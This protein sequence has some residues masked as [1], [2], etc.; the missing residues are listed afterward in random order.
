[1][2]SFSDSNRVAV[3]YIKEATW[4]TTPASPTMTALPITSEGFQSN[5]NTVT[6]DTIRDDRNVAD[7]TV[8]GGGAE[9]DVG[10]E[11]RKADWDPLFEGAL[12]SQFVTTVVTSAT[13]SAYFSAAYIQAD[14]SALNNV[15]VGQFLRV[16]D[17]QT[18]G[19]D[20]DYRVLAVS[21]IAAGTRRVTVADASSN[22]SATFT[23]EIVSGSATVQGRRLRNGVTPTSY[24]IEK[25]FADIGVFHILR[26]MRVAS[27]ALNFESQSILTGSFGFTGKSQIAS[28][29]T[30]GASTVAATTNP[31]MNASGNL[32]RIWEGSEAV[33]GVYFQSLSLDLNNNPREQPVVGSDELAGVGTGRCEIT[34]SL[35]AYFEDNALLTKFVNGTATNFRFQVTDSNGASYIFSIPNVRLNEGTVIA[36]GPNEDIIQE[37]SW[38]AFIDDS[39]LYALQI[40]I[41]D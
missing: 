17:A 16:K 26:G 38:G 4:G 24:S 33:S 21:T 31:V 37:F 5:I 14:S 36:G 6:S 3:R 34:G 40:D 1:M 25:E 30:I 7:I 27:M 41:L 12:Q 9:G 2:P 39:G 11:L 32:Q 28:T 8:V 13:A 10:F 15:L 23:G 19:N 35:S 22:S 29:T 18:A 20:G